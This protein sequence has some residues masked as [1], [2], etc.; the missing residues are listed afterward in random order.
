MNKMGAGK[1]GQKNLR[2]SDGAEFDRCFAIYRG[3]DEMDSETEATV[4]V[5]PYLQVT[6]TLKQFKITVNCDENDDFLRV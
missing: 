2:N 3:F 6:K 1:Q 5:A 4:S